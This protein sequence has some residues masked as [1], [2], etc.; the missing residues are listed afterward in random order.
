MALATTSSSSALA[1]P[2]GPDD[3][4]VLA[5]SC[6]NCHGPAGRSRGTIPPI[7]GRPEGELKSVLLAFRDG[8]PTDATVMPR[9][10][11]AYDDAQIQA[12]AHYFAVIPKE[13]GR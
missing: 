13:A 10:A 11:K 9:I 6:T 1:D 5:G 12:L 2:L 7:A 8:E 4:A 3:V